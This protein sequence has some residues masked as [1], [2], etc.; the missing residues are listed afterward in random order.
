MRL[1]IRLWQEWTSLL[2]PKLC[3]VCEKGIAAHSEDAICAACLQ[4]LPYTDYYLLPENPVT[5]RLAGRVRLVF[6]GAYCYYRASGTMQPIIHALKYYNR[7]EIG[8]ALGYDYGQQLK[9]VQSLTDINYLIPVPIHPKRLHQRGYNQAE[10]IAAGMAK[11]LAK[12]LLIDGLVRKHFEAS[13]TKKGQDDRAQNVANVFAA[14]A[15]DLAGQHLLLVDD[16]LTTGATLEACADQL[17][18]AYPG[19]RL[20][21][22]VLGVTEG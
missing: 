20:S 12:P 16:V 8:L 4:S 19:V 10:R 7:P 13:Q 15:H 21:L 9:T 1:P 11:A 18:A 6:G 3:L 5:D 22:A 14:G 17:L 2:F